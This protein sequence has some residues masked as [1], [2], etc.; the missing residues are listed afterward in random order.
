M[1]KWKIG[2]KW[3]EYGE[4]GDNAILASNAMKVRDRLQGLLL[5][6]SKFKQTNY[7][8]FPLKSSENHTFSDDFREN[9]S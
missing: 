3:V 2:F 8:L 4:K 5:I 1:P 6:L 9:R 7:L